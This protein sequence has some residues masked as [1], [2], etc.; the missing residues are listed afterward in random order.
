MV[1]E[2]LAILVSLG[3]LMFFAYRGYPV[4]VFAPIFTLLAAVLSGLALMPSY[5]ET[6]MTN[7]A[8]YVKSFFPVFLLGAIF[9][10]VMEMNGAAAS[11]A[12]SIVKALGSNRAILAVV[13]ACSILTYGGVSLFVVAFAV[14]PFAAAIFR[15]ANIPKRLIPGAIALGAFTYTMDALPG[16]PQI[17]NIIPTNYFGT[18]AYA[19]PL[20]GIIGAVMVFSG[21]L[22]WLERRRK[23]A[24]AAGEGYGEGHINEPELNREQTYMNIWLAV[25]PLVL[26]LV[27]NYL[28]SRGFL[29]VETW[30]DP[31]LLKDNYNIDKVKNV[32]SSWALIIALSIG[33]LAAVLINLNQVKTKLASGL[34][35][36]AMGALL[37]IFNTASEVGFGNVVKTLPGF[38]LIQEWILGVSSHPLVSEAVAVNVLAG[39][40]GSAS[41]GMSIALEVMGKQYLELAQAAGISP[42]L[43]HRIASMASGGM[44]TLPHN[45]AVITLLA[46]TGLT[47]RQS[48]KDI[49]AITVLKTLTVFI[50]AIAASLFV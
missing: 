43:L 49:F 3:L 7:A 27:S 45:G 20:V 41:G 17:Q 32:A 14:Y 12:Q 21:G 30:Y 10:K 33:I 46:I 40:T 42:E 18:D 19:A 25:L 1:I 44:D 6:F 22:F 26:V 50:L 31:Q 36:A 13:L 39:I 23:Q 16:T 15:E 47:H 38:K 35:T 34:T 9:G 5:T 48:Y 4:I 29:S 24:A 2:V 28:F 37:A 8:N 11:I